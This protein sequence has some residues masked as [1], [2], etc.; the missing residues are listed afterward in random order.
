MLSIELP[1]LIDG[2][3]FF[4]VGR[5][6]ESLNS[7]MSLDVFSELFVVNAIRIVNAAVPFCYSDQF[8]ALLT[9]KPRSIVADIAETLHY[10]C[11]SL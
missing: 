11:F 5:I 1:W 8:N 4:K 6:W 7:F 9:E 2:I 3:F 10:Q